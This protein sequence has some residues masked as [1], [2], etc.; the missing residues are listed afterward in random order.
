MEKGAFELKW[1]LELTLELKLRVKVMV[2][3]NT[4][5]GRSEGPGNFGLCK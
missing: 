5:F 4:S 2:K 1:K 3:G